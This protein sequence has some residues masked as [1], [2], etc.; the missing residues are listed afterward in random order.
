MSTRFWNIRRMRA[1][2]HHGDLRGSLL[3]AALAGLDQHGEL[4]SWRAL[5][6]A[7][8]VSQTAPYR[9]FENLEAL[10]IAV[11]TECFAR[12]TQTIRAATEKLHDPFE[13]LARGLQAYV[14]FGRAHPSWY[15]LMFGRTLVKSG[16]EALQAAGATAYGT[17]VEAIAAC[18]V[19]TPAEV[20]FTLW[21]AVHGITDLAASNL[22]PPLPKRT[23]HNPTDS[24]VTM[25]V[26]H[27]REVLRMQRAS[28]VRE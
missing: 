12:L 5:A 10:Q 25:C 16:D 15:E 13:R 8:A 6:R 21:C 9:H 7:C 24:V 4:P 2:Y 18:E 11:A 26:N 20:A 27:V 28:S 23:R 1:Q 22:Q 19:T 17:L 3:E 14:A